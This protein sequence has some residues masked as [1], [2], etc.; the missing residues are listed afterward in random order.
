MPQCSLLMPAKRIMGSQIEARLKCLRFCVLVFVLEV[1]YSLSQMILWLRLIFMKEFFFVFEGDF[2]MQIPMR[3]VIVVW[4]L[5]TNR[6]RYFLI[7]VNDIV[8]YTD[9]FDFLIELKLIVDAILILAVKK[10][11]FHF[12]FQMHIPQIQLTNSHFAT[13]YRHLTK[14][15]L[16]IILILLNHPAL[17][18]ILILII[19]PAVD[20]TIFIALFSFL[21]LLI[22]SIQIFK[23]VVITV[24]HLKR[25]L[26][27]ELW[28]IFNKK[29][30]L[31]W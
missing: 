22:I 3:L 5:T 26:M 10:Q 6:I 18:E 12:T 21:L 16:P 20:I 7:F 31:Y 23:T 15:L 1:F 25:T 27:I 29:V 19:T 17:I 13:I 28:F 11:L 24:A 9:L 4:I 30:F 2:L 8:W 14:L